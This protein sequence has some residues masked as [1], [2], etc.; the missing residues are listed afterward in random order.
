MIR[1]HLTQWGDNRPKV[2]LVPGARGDPKV[3]NEFPGGLTKVSRAM[4]NVDK[5]WMTSK[6]F[7]CHQHKSMRCE[8]A[9]L[10]LQSV[11]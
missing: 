11:C 5:C 10:G 6:Q 3:L 1:K 8:T 9:V 2:V 7:N 4:T